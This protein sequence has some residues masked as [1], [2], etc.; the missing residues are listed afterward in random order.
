MAIPF[1]EANAILARDTIGFCKKYL[2]AGSQKGDWWLVCVPWRVDKTPSL[3]V[4]L[5]TGRWCDF[6]REGDRGDLVDLKARL[7]RK[8][9]TDIVRELVQ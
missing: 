2:P 8:S 9:T 5:K 4:N 3:G 7:E 1:K 6:G